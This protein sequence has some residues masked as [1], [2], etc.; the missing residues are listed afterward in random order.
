MAFK[1]RFLGC[2]S[3]IIQIPAERKKN[4]RS[5]LFTVYQNFSIPSHFSFLISSKSR[6]MRSFFKPASL[7]APFE[8]KYCW[9]VL[10]FSKHFSF[11]LFCFKPQGF[12]N[13]WQISVQC[14]SMNRDFLTP[15]HFTG[16]F[17]SSYNNLCS[18]WDMYRWWS[19]LQW[20]DMAESGL[21]LAYMWTFWKVRHPNHFS[22]VCSSSPLHF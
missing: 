20:A 1:P 10:T 13:M 16:N 4:Q 14:F 19:L 22:W 3:F 11:P 21:A 9:I 12:F 7:R 18:R 6:K 2:G 5:F 17:P 15:K 8:K